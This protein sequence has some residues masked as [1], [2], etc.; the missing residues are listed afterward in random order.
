MTF[1]RGSVEIAFKLKD[2]T[3]EE[4]IRVYRLKFDMF[5]NTGTPVHGIHGQIVVRLFRPC[6]L[7]E[8]YKKT[9]THPLQIF[10]PLQDHPEVVPKMIQA[11]KLLRVQTNQGPMAFSNQGPMAFW[12]GVPS[13]NVRTVY[14]VIDHGSRLLNKVSVPVPQSSLDLW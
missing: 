3:N 2:L 10:P 9:Q 11:S 1:F 13:S 8:E 12:Y 14:V 6:N 5:A 4:E 7:T